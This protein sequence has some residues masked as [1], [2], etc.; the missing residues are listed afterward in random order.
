M[1]TTRSHNPRRFTA[2]SG[3]SLKSA[4][5]QL[6]IAGLRYDAQLKTV[7]IPTWRMTGESQGFSQACRDAVAELQKMGFILQST[8]E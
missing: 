3:F 1:P 6:D 4:L 2:A 7:Y 5:A 8:I